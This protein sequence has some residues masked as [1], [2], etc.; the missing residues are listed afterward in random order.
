MAKLTAAG[1]RG[2]RSPGR[3]GDGDGLWLDVKSAELRYWVYRYKRGGRERWMSLG[4]ADDVTL[5]QARAAHAEARGLLL[6]GLDPLDERGKTKLDLTHRFSEVAEACIASHEPGWRGA[7]SAAQWRSSIASYVLPVLGKVPVAEIGVEHV[8]RCLRP[9]WTDKPETA[10]RVRSR[11]E[12]ILDYA[13][14]MG[15]RTAGTN[16]AVW[17]GGL[18]PLLVAKSK[19]HSVEHLA[20]LDWRQAPQL[21]ASLADETNM[22]S[23]C[24]LFLIFTAVRSGEARGARWDEIDLDQRVW[25]IPASRMKAGKVHRVPLSEPAMAI[26]REL[27]ALRTGEFVFFGRQGRPV[28]YVPLRALLRKLGHHDIT[29]HGFRSSFRDWAADTGKS[30]DV[31]EMALAHTVGSQVA[32][33]Y[34]RSDLLEQRRGL[35]N[36]WADF[37]TREPAQVVP[38]RVA[39]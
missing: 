33:A 17:R 3:Y 34:Q 2:L 30:S 5:A 37:L 38:L 36:S 24:L 25:T 1:V 27:A 4:S 16:P 10:S 9:I 14:A 35:M 20:A 19:L 26:L 29:L 39:G 12:A 22:G 7:G 6:R 23:R 11:I 18:K 32:R 28:S 31:A 21:I 13:T 15:W 8:L